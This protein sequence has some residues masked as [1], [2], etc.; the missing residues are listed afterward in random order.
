M[1]RVLRSVREALAATSSNDACLD[2]CQ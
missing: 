2:R 1:A